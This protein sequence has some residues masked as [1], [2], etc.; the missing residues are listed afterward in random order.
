MPWFFSHLADSGN[1]LLFFG[2]VLAV[3]LL[4]RLLKGSGTAKSGFPPLSGVLNALDGEISKH[5]SPQDPADTREILNQLYAAFEAIDQ[6][7]TACRQSDG[8][9][10]ATAIYD[11]AV[12]LNTSI[13]AEIAVLEASVQAY[14]G[15]QAA[16][17]A[18]LAELNTVI[19]QKR[20]VDCKVQRAERNRKQKIMQEA[21]ANAGECRKHLHSLRDFSKRQSLYI[22]HCRQVIGGLF[23]KAGRDWEKTKLQPPCHR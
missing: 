16:N 12:R 8:L 4:C 3:A 14:A 18:R 2:A 10:A 7:W 11:A 19:A 20:G 15:S 1:P 23:G 9:E 22:R 5:P 17:G 13:S 6:Q 21:S